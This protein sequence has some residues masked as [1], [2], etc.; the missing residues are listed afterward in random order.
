MTLET[1]YTFTPLA[2]TQPLTTAIGRSLIAFL[3]MP[4]MWH[5]S[6][7]AVTSLYDSGASSITSLGLATRMAIPCVI[8]IIEAQ[9]EDNASATT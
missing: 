4:A 7:T 5:V 1:T 3:E 9:R 8:R 6:T 2:A